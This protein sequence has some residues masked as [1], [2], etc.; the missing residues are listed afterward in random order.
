MIK[1]TLMTVAVG[2]FVLASF[3]TPAQAGHCPK[4]VKKINAAMSKMDKAKM[5]MAK[6]AAAKGMAL[7]KAKKH[8]ESIKVLHETMEKYGIKH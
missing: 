5:S 4:D 6:D 3:G 7:H 2:A 8:G 1:K